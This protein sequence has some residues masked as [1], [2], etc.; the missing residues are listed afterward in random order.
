[1]NE[2]E[3]WE[4][5]VKGIELCMIPGTGGCEDCPYLGKGICQQ[6][7]GENALELLKAQEPVVRC[8]DCKHHYFASNRVLHE[9]SYV[10]DKHGINVTLTWYCADGERE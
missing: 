10:C 8:K 6:L 4:K 2:Q 7:L 3:K 9:Q 5:V 1:M